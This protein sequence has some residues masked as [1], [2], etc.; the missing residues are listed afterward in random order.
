MSDVTLEQHIFLRSQMKL[1]S[2]DKTKFSDVFRGQ[3]P[4]V[5]AKVLDLTL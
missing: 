2:D 5:K 4:A 3:S 1:G